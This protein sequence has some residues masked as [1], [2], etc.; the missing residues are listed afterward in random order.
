MSQIKMYAVSR[1]FDAKDSPLSSTKLVVDARGFRWTFDR[2][3]SPYISHKVCEIEPVEKTGWLVIRNDKHA[4]ALACDPNAA[5]PAGLLR[6][7]RSRVVKEWY[8]MEHVP[9]YVVQDVLNRARS[10]IPAGFDLADTDPV[11]L[12]VETPKLAWFRDREPVYW[13]AVTET[14]NSP[15]VVELPPR[16]DWEIDRWGDGIC[17]VN[18]DAGTFTER[19]PRAT[20]IAWRG[21]RLEPVDDHYQFAEAPVAFKVRFNDSVHDA[22][23]F[24]VPRGKYRLAGNG[25]DHE[26][27]DVGENLVFIGR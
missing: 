1:L 23:G 13:G 14:I 25:I 8:V 7:G 18:D 24:A 21:Y 27:P 22:E 6:P 11:R 4:I 9:G 17:L 5:P 15:I 16:E 26:I 19:L 20:A 2:L 3:N 12:A 10:L